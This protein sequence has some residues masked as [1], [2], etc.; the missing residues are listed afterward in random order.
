M[1]VVSEKSISQYDV[2][3]DTPPACW[4]DG[5]VMGNGSLGAVYY[6]PE[7]LTFLINKTDV[8]DARTKKIKRVIPSAEVAEM[9]RNGATVQDFNNEEILENPPDGAGPK[10]C[11]MLQMDMGMTAGAGTRSAL[12]AISSRLSLCDG[13]VNIKLDKHLC[14]PRLNSFIDANSNT[15][16]FRAREIS[17][18]VSFNNRIFFS[19]PE[20]IAIGLPELWSDNDRLFMKMMIPESGYYIVGLQVIPRKTTAF[21]KLIKTKIREKCHPPETGRLDYEIQGNYGIINVGGDFD[22]FLTVVTDKDSDDPLKTV[23]DNL[24]DSVNRGVDNI[25]S[26][27]AEWW[28]KFWSRSSVDLGDKALNSLFYRS[29]YALGS[30]YRTAPMSGLLGVCY[31]PT[32][33][34]IQYAPWGGDLHNDQNVQCPFYPVFAL[35]H[36]ELF[37]AYRDTYQNFLPEARRLAAEVFDAPGAHFDMSFN[38]LGKSI[39]HGVGTYRHAFMGSYVAFIH[40][41]AWR[42]KQDVAELKEYIYPFLKEI[43]VFYQS[44]LKKG[45][46]G[47]YRLWPAMA[48]E[49]DVVDCANPVQTISMLKICLETAIEAVDVL[50]VDFDLQQSWKEFLENLPDYP[51]GVDQKGRTVVLDGEGIHPDHHVGQGGSLYPVYPCNEF[52]E[53]SA[54]EVL[55]LYQQTYESVLD[56]TNE[57]ICAD[58]ETYYYKCVWACFYRAMTALRLGDTDSFWLHYLPMFMKAYVKPN[59][60]CSHDACVIVESEVSEK[61]LESIP[62]ESLLD[63]DELMPKF[64]PWCGH[65]G[66]STPNSDAKRFAVPLIEAS[67]DYLTM[68]TETLLQSHNGIIRVFPAWPKD[69]DAKFENLIAEGDITVSSEIK[70]GHVLFVRFEKGE[71]CRSSSFRIK[72]PWTGEIEEY[73][74]QGSG[75]ISI[76]QE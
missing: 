67:A 1:S 3:Y 41:L 70:S 28:N 68:I 16:V 42:Y 65:E 31:G 33:G 48:V 18:I 64:E 21:R 17:S 37:D 58:A 20:D 57:M 30:S 59:G 13:T 71:N 53:F 54:P 34:P 66:T 55:R 4:Q 43:L 36:S 6:A 63:V 7:A 74:F 14:H 45:D 69:R 46:N 61:H 9:I 38:A 52:D 15:F 75:M 56:K 10:T 8:I 39:A 12:P 23:N 29:L 25:Y 35:N 50:G 5:F 49:L 47:R 2:V 27:H 73:K 19:R 60:L 76:Q 32:P 26:G 24:N 72:S 44:M 22:L 62:D 51:Q 11:C 40:C